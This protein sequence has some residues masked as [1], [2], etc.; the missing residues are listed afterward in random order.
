MMLLQIF[1]FEDGFSFSDSSIIS[2]TAFFELSHRSLLNGFFNDV[3]K[4]DKVLDRFGRLVGCVLVVSE[5]SPS[6]L[7]VKP[8]VFRL[9]CSS[10][11]VRVVRS[12][13]SDLDGSCFLHD[14]HMHQKM[15]IKIIPNSVAIT[16]RVATS[17]SC[18]HINPNA[19][20]KDTKL[21]SRKHP[22]KTWF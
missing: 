2:S 4:D 14:V 20:R 7:N 11:K 1:H 6:L 19:I 18:K 10:S 16:E 21:L 15:R 9:A 8:F 5:S 13:L 12:G 22:H 17:E 3:L